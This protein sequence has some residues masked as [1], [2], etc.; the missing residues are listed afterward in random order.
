MT[1]VISFRLQNADELKNLATQKGITI[2]TL[3]SRIIEKYLNYYHYIENYNFIAMPRNMLMEMY[4]QLDLTKTESIVDI[5]TKI[6]LADL[7]LIY[8][9]PKLLDIINYLHVWFDHNSFILKHFDKDRQFKLVC[10]HE[11][12]KN[13]SQITA[14]ILTQI[15]IRLGYESK[16]TEVLEGNFSFQV[17]KKNR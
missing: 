9:D 7:K 17:D 11:M 6:A 13:W 2:S 3:S 1:E 14:E 16:V 10:R 15:F 12:G 4:N 5:G 8:D